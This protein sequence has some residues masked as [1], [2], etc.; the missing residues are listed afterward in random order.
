M[1]P[2]AWLPFKISYA[3]TCQLMRAL[4]KA[5]HEKGKKIICVVSTA[6]PKTK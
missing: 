3:P 5:P 1:A 6:F 4:N 2:P